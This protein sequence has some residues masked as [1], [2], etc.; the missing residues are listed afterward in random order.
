M[1]GKNLS[2]DLS[3]GIISTPSVKPVES[4]AMKDNLPAKSRRRP[5][6]GDAAEPDKGAPEVPEAQPHQIDRL[7]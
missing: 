6:L 5:R 2:S 3:F 4:N 1:D 7:A